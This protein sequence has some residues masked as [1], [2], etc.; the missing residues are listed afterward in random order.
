MDLG[1]IVC[2]RS[3]PSCDNCP[4]QNDCTAWKEKRT[5]RLPTAKLRRP[6]PEKEIVFLMLMKQKKI[7]LEK[8]PAP[9]IWGELW[10]PPEMLT[11]EDAM[12]FCAQHYNLQTIPVID[13]P[14]LSHSFTH[15]KLRI[16]PKLLT[17]ISLSDLKQNKGKWLTLNEALASAIPAPVKKLL[18]QIEYNQYLLQYI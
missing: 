4:L 9:G 2:T 15:F 10:C 7:L 13:L 6:L 18:K 16:Y 11:S 5:D 17:V 14:P 8:R 1:A 12:N 3:K